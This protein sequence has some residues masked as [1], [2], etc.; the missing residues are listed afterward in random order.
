ML[1]YYNNIYMK[2]FFLI[3][4]AI[5]PVYSLA[6]NNTGR[7]QQRELHIT[8]YYSWNDGQ[9]LHYLSGKGIP[10]TDDIYLKN[11]SRVTATGELIQKTGTRKM[12]TKG[13]CVD[14]RGNIFDC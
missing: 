7:S 8:E 13:Q 1:F 10:F 5:L 12:I 9:F 2:R 4:L 11:G 3:L 14:A 6:Q